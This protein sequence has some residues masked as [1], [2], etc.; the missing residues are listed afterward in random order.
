MD[1]LGGRRLPIP[2]LLHVML[3]F[4][5]LNFCSPSR[6]TCAKRKVESSLLQNRSRFKVGQICSD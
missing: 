6:E 4:Y 2:D 1:F 5:N 3:Q